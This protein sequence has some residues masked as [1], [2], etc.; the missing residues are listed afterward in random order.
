MAESFKLT[1]AVAAG[2]AVPIDHP[3]LDED[4]PSEAAEGFLALTH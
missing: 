1:A 2:A 4:G 3:G